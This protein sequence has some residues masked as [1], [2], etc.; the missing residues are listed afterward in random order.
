MRQRPNHVMSYAGI[1]LILPPLI[2]PES[3][4]R[5]HPT[6]V[7]NVHSSG[8]W[9]SS[10]HISALVSIYAPQHLALLLSLRLLSPKPRT[11]EARVVHV[12]H[13][14]GLQ[15]GFVRGGRRRFVGDA[16]YEDGRA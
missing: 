12:V 16:I 3:S 2:L 4:Y 14:A 7:L 6:G 11:L 9:L 10:R 15:A 13:D 8:A 5:S 1:D